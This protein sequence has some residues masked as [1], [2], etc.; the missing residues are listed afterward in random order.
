VISLE[1][2]G[3][4]YSD[5]IAIDDISID[6]AKGELFGVV[7]PDG[8][9]KSTLMKILATTTEPDR[10]IYRIGGIEI[11]KMLFNA[12]E[13]IAYMPQ[14]FGLYED[15]TVEENAIFF[16]KLFGIS[17]HDARK[18]LKKLYGFSR[19]GDFHDRLA[20]KLSGGM[21]QKLGLICSLI[22]TP[23]ILILDEPTNGVDPVS[24]REF[25]MILYE[26]L[27]DGVTIIVST[28][29]LDEAERCARVALMNNGRFLSVNDPASIKN[30]IGR[31]LAVITGESPDGI[32]RRL[33]TSY[34][35]TAIARTGN[36]LRMFVPARIAFETFRKKVAGYGKNVSV[37]KETPTLEDC[38]LEL[39]SENRESGGSAS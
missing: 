1:S 35:Q 33:R 22:H 38:F 14:R 20:G 4:R 19:L 34:P 28:S 32:K 39:I 13:K 24:R 11:S 23:D 27:A 25:W 3:K 7:G 2:I 6:I 18:R 9:G 10:G 30:S 12:R 21:K 16:A 17:A 29:Y 8:A 36:N 26:L 31:P 37:R 5:R 15:L